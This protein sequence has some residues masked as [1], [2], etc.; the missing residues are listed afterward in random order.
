MKGTKVAATPT[1]V[2]VAPKEAKEPK[3]SK[4]KNYEDTAKVTLLVKENPKREGSASYERFEGYKGAKTVADA[5]ANGVTR[6]DLD[7]DAKHG[8]ITIAGWDVP[9]IEK[10]AKA[11]A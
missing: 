1:K 6:A 7:W 2:P 8:Y 4:A 3:A 10:K 5:L 11:E 9:V